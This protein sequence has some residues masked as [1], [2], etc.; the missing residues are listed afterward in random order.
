MS[1]SVPVSAV[2]EQLQSLYAS[3]EEDL[4]GSTNRGEYIRIQLHMRTVQNILENFD[5]NI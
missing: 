1:A 3:L 4:N 5:L 2:Q